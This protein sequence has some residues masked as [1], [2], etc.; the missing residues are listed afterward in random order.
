MHYATFDTTKSWHYS[1]LIKSNAEILNQIKIQQKRIDESVQ[2]ARD[3]LTKVK[4]ADREEKWTVRSLNYDL[5]SVE[6]R[7]QDI[8]DDVR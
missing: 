7:N 2:K 6:Q 8:Y 3:D 5:I 4:A 1:N